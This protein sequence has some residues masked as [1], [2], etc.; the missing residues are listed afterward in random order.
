MSNSQLKTQQIQGPE[1]VGA[2]NSEA[3]SAAVM[4]EEGVLLEKT[5]TQTTQSEG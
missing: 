2:S 4:P 1:A 3:Y 5:P